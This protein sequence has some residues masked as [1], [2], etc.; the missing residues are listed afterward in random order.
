VK[1][2]RLRL[3]D[4]AALLLSLLVIGVLSA[5]AYSTRG[6]DSEVVVEA[7]GTQ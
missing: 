3:L 1:G 6:G 4:L 2:R 5:A 7:A